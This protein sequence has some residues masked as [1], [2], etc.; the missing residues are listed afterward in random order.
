MAIG[1][2]YLHRGVLCS[3]AQVGLQS[4]VFVKRELHK[5]CSEQFLKFHSQNFLFT[6]QNPKRFF[7]NFFSSN[8]VQISFYEIKLTF[9]LISVMNS[10]RVVFPANFSYED[11][12]PFECNEDPNVVLSLA[13]Y[14]MQ[15]SYLIV[16]AVLNVMIVYTVF[17]GNSY[18]DNSFYMLYCADAI[19]VGQF[20]ME[21]VKYCLC[22]DL[23]SH[24]VLIS[25]FPKFKL[26]NFEILFSVI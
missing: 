26:N 18:R 10:S 20:N 22:V 21:I 3:V 16:G 24:S 12:L 8:F 25:C 7:I 15:S 1:K 5:L 4:C 19:V 23:Q 6:I 9:F 2:H 14:G 13:M 11:P 17:H